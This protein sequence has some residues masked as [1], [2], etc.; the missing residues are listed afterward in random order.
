MVSRASTYL[1]AVRIRMTSAL[2]CRSAHR[3]SSCLDYSAHNVP[4]DHG[5]RL[6][7]LQVV[8]RDEQRALTEMD[9][10]VMQ[11]VLR[12]AQCARLIVDAFPAAPSALPLAEAVA[13][14]HEGMQ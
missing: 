8:L 12:P 5:T 2:R 7:G 6:L 4:L 14:M 1:T 13:S 11:S 10:T 9:D 3:A